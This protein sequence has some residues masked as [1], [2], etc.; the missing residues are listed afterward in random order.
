MVI[1]A[2]SG[3]EEL[4]NGQRCKMKSLDMDRDDEIQFPEC[5]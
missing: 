2:G 4:L 5:V 1:R 3:R